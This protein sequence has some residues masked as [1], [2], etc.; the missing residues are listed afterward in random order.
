[1]DNFI[2]GAFAKKI[3]KKKCILGTPYFASIRMQYN[4]KAVEV[5]VNTIGLFVRRTESCRH[6]PM[7]A[8]IREQ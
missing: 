2:F 4:S 1:M 3:K 6:I 8:K 7:L 5:I